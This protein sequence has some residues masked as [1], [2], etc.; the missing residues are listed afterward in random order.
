MRK[1]LVPLVLALF[2]G[3]ML[4]SCGHKE[5]PESYIAG[6]WVCTSARLNYNGANYSTSKS[7]ISVNDTPVPTPESLSISVGGKAV[8]DGYD[9]GTYT[10][11][12][13]AGT[14]TFPTRSFTFEIPYGILFVSRQLTGVESI[15][16]NNQRLAGASTATITYWFEK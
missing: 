10:Y 14:M 8:M 5:D 12:D 2:S 4:C 16:I 9:Q 15:V 6:D 7:S 1:I 13:K 3:L 11:S